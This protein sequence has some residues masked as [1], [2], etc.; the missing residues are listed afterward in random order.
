MTISCSFVKKLLL[1]V[2][3][4]VNVEL[5][6]YYNLEFTPAACLSGRLA[7]RLFV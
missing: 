2:S 3:E 7:V 1:Q 6:E 5:C 4:I